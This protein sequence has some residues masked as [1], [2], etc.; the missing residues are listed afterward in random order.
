M[1]L[2]N[3]HTFE[4][5][6]FGDSS[7]P[8]YYIA[9]HKWTTDETTY[10]DVKKQRNTGSPGYKKIR[11]YCSFLQRTNVPST[12]S[13]DALGIKRDCEWLWIDTS[14]IDKKSSAELTE[15]INSMFKYYA[16]SEVCY[17]YLQDVGT[18]EK[19]ES[20]TLDLMQ[21]VWFRRGWTLQELLAPRVVVFLT[22]DWEILGHKCRLKFCD[23]SCD[24]FGECLNYKI[25]KITNISNQR[26]R[27]N[28]SNGGAVAMR[29]ASLW[30]SKR[31]TERVE[32]R[33][34]CILGIL[35]LNLVPIYG[36]GTRAWQRLQDEY[37]KMTERQ[38]S[39]T[40]FR[41][42]DT[43]NH[44]QRALLSESGTNTSSLVVSGTP[45]AEMFRTGHDGDK[46]GWHVDSSRPAGLNTVPA[47][48]ISFDDY[49]G[50]AFWPLTSPVDF[51]YSSAQQN[52]GRATL[53]IQD[54]NSELSYDLCEN[55]D[56]DSPPLSG[57]AGASEQG[58]VTEAL[59]AA[60]LSN[61]ER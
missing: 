14:C 36:E 8:P 46:L 9:S 13:M 42:F 54:L 23:S 4:L 44:L 60:P 19:Y 55:N 11:D 35:G 22:R 5:A 58:A 48:I 18:A 37:Q 30:I 27:F 56:M 51:E 49:H 29:E 47:E 3:I 28:W 61:I 57:R 12:R 20:A 7:I 2:L 16:K 59:D 32:D 50:K 10:K 31:T 43:E 52:F 53:H 33:A 25:E 26:L 39:N 24:G 40:D 17:A 34:Y 21:S 38:L 41:L 15:S 45:S 6:E 1:R